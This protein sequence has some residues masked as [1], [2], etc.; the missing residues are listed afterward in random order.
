MYT[1]EQSLTAPFP[2]TEA[3][4]STL[5]SVIRKDQ[6]PPLFLSIETTGLVKEQ[7]YV[8]LIGAAK[9]VEDSVFLIQWFAETPSEEKEILQAFLSFLKTN[10][11]TLIHFNGTAFALSF[12][13]E[14]CT[15]NDLQPSFDA[16][17]SLDL[18]REAKSLKKLLTLPGLRQAELEAALGFAPRLGIK[19][20]SCP[21]LYQR[22]VGLHTEEIRSQLL[23]HNY[24]SLIGLSRLTSLLTYRQLKESLYEITGCTRSGADRIFFCLTLAAPLPKP[25][26]LSFMDCVLE[27]GE[28]TAALTCTLSPEGKLRL[29]HRDYRSYDYLPLE[30][31]AIP[32]SLSAYLDRSLRQ[33]ATPQT[34][35]TWFSCSETFL[36][37]PDLQRRYLD[38][39]LQVLLLG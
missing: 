13:E 20:R 22:Y 10:S 4:F 16:Y 15:F 26:T 8:F 2:A 28:K 14:R 32:R 39:L 21:V 38:A 29:Y 12:L 35:Y 11:G 36:N 6:W 19:A 33:P 23:F 9:P 34:C 18:Y 27:A 7:S 24:E 25:F 1:I 37:S 5:A 31:Q 3:L 30:D 17:G